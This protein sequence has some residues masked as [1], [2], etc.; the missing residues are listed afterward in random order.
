MSSRRCSRPTI[1]Q[2]SAHWI[3]SAL[4]PFIR[5]ATIIFLKRDHVLYQHGLYHSTTEITTRGICG[6]EPHHPIVQLRNPPYRCLTNSKRTHPVKRI[7]RGT[8]IDGDCVTKEPRH[9]IPLLAFAA[10][11]IQIAFVERRYLLTMHICSRWTESRA[12]SSGAILRRPELQL[13][14]SRPVQLLRQRIPLHASN[15]GWH[16][17]C[18]ALVAQAH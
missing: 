10:A 5:S 11:V 1:G 15:P 2:V 13:P 9:D 4:R 6:T 16:S 17:R 14:L 7:R 18:H 3:R 12:L 8:I